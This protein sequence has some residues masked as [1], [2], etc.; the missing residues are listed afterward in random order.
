MKIITQ[1]LIEN[2][3]AYLIQEEKAVNTIQKYIRDV[4][5]FYSGGMGDFDKMCE[6]A[7]RTLKWQNERI[8]LYLIAPYMKSGFNKD[9]EYYEMLYD[10]IIIPD[11]GDIHY[12]R[13]I[14]ARNKWM[15]EQADIM[16]CH[17][18]RTDGGAYK[19]YSYAKRLNKR[20]IMLT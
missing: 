13:A 12:K 3:K 7:V 10:E 1:E 9:R 11:L 4:T 16:L 20:L 18:V 5:A 19:T 17:V 8:K 2:F 14:G 6:S 15:A